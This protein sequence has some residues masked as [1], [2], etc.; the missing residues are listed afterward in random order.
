MSN[1]VVNL[2]DLD[3]NIDDNE[4]EETEWWGIYVNVKGKRR[5]KWG[6]YIIINLDLNTFKY[7]T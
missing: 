4:E 6:M 3:L 5:G 7:L 2:I 1:V